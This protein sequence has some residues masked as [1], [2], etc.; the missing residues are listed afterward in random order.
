MNRV[1][2]NFKKSILLLVILT[3]AAMNFAF[4]AEPELKV[5]VNKNPVSPGDKFELTYTFSGMPERFNTPDLRDFQVHTGPIDQVQ[6]NFTNAGVSQSIVFSYILS[7]KQEGTFRIGSASVDFNNKKITSKTIDIKVTKNTVS[8]NQ[9]NEVDLN[10]KVFMESQV[11]RSSAYEG[12]P[13]VVTYKLY[14]KVDLTR[15][16]IDALPTFTGFWS[17]EVK[18]PAQPVFKS[19]IRAGVEFHAAEIKK[20]IL[21]PQQT[22]ELVIPAMNAELG[23]RVRDQRNKKTYSNPIDQ[24]FND[25]FSNDPFFSGYKEVPFKTSTGQKKIKINALPQPKPATFNGAVGNFKIQA[26]TDRTE[27]KAS[28]A[29]K[30]T[31]KI[32]GNGNLRLLE[33]R[34]PE[35]P[36]NIETYEP[37]VSEAITISSTNLTGSKT[38]E[39]LLIPRVSGK[40][41]IRDYTLSYFDP[42]SK[43]YKELFVPGFELHVEPGDPSSSNGMNSSGVEV[44]KLNDDIAFIK[45]DS[46]LINDRS[47][48]LLQ[49]I[50]FKV[51]LILPLLLFFFF[52]GYYKKNEKIESDSI[53]NN[54]LKARSKAKK[55]LKFA[56]QC[57][58]SSDRSKFW[59]HLA[60]GVWGY[61][62]DKLNIPQA[63]L[64]IEKVSEELEVRNCERETIEKLTTLIRKIETAR[65]APVESDGSIQESYDNAVDCLSKIENE[66][67]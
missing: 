44:N 34:S 38:F 57:I 11:S 30:F 4:A 18:L 19:E 67:K 2:N 35:L 7:A 28:E 16:N 13:I 27:L 43:S 29:V 50:W 36:P 45:T 66:I 10:G 65:Y 26:S 32:S 48:S 64:S 23:V 25:P 54:R 15:Y 49:N 1:I 21:F 6:T 3:C 52:V 53:L 40:Y 37:K 39:Y 33:P 61:C 5:S 12:E 8:Q 24:F 59:E 42:E 9:G 31:I 22:G 47:Q 58:K 41:K 55:K 14:T 17:E 63:K 46:H 56:E 20:F 62:A 51:S 60:D